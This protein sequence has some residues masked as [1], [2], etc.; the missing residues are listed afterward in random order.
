LPEQTR[1]QEVFTYG[2]LT[3]GRT[4]NE[5]GTADWWHLWRADGHDLGSA[6]RPELLVHLLPRPS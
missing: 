2:P 5:A 1:V 3:C 6:N 4:T